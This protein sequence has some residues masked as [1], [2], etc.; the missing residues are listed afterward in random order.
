MTRWGII[1]LVAYLV[2]GLRVVD[3][4]RAVRQAVCLTAAVVAFV[5]VKGHAL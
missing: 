4:R 1:L 3:G 2:I 5:F